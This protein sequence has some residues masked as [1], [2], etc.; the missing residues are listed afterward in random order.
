MG[1][2]VISMNLFKCFM[3]GLVVAGIYSCVRESPATDKANLKDV[4]QLLDPEK[5]RSGRNVYFTGIEGIYNYG[6][7]L[8]GEKIEIQGVLYKG[9][10]MGIVLA[11]EKLSCEKPTRMAGL[12]ID[13]SMIANSCYG[14][15]VTT[16]AIVPREK[17]RLRIQLDSVE[18]IVSYGGEQCI[19]FEKGE[20]H[21][22]LPR[23]K[24]L[25]L[26]IRKRFYPTPTGTEGKLS[27]ECPVDD[28][29]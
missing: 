10:M 23:C 16:T 7:L 21:V 22:Q 27:L 12:S 14:R 11:T 1:S 28:S 2:L 29:N 26:P 17:Q 24:E 19:C 20:H 25:A 15:W 9:D 5:D 4:H 3:T 6:G 18:L 8:R 13:D